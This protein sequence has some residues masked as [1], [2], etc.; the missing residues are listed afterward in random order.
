MEPQGLENFLI[1]EP[2]KLWKMLYWHVKN[3]K[4]K[5]HYQPSGTGINNLLHKVI[6]MLWS[7]DKELWP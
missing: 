2:I 4:Q 6:C 3:M 1:L 5:T 7:K